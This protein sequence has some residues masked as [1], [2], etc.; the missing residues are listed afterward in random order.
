MAKYKEGRQGWHQGTQKL[1]HPEYQT[2]QSDFPESSQYLCSRKVIQ[3]AMQDT[4]TV[5]F[6]RLGSSS[7]GL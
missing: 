6:R 2:G 7:A 3:E 1:D 4:A 5:K